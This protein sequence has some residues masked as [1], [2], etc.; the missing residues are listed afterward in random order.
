[1]EIAP[2]EL[3]MQSNIEAQQRASSAPQ[4]EVIDHIAIAV[5]DL[6]KAVILFRD[7][8]GFELKKR[9]HIKGKHSG[10][11]SAEME[12]NGIK[13]VLCQGTEPASQVSQLVSKHGVGVAHIALRVKDV[14]GTVGSLKSNGMSFDTSVIEGAGLT[15][16]FSTRESNT[17]LSFEFIARNGEDEFLETNVQSLFDQLEASNKY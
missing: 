8:L 7:V 11:I 9:R 16:A 4:Y 5:E 17:G 6:E 10:M 2:A 12:H 1:M 3:Q 13:F 14:H 15:H